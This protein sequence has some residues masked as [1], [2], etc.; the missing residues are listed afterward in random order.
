[1]RPSKFLI[2]VAAILGVAVGVPKAEA[3][4]KK[5]PV[6]AKTTAVKSAKKTTV[7]K[8]AR[9]KSEKKPVEKPMKRS[10]KK[11]P[12]ILA[13][14]TAEVLTPE[15]PHPHRLSPEFVEALALGEL[16]QAYHHLQLEEASDK[17][18]YMINQ[19]L[20]A[21]GKGSSHGASISPFDRATAWHNLYLFLARQGRPA[22]KFVKEAARYYLKAAHK[23]LYHEKSNVL[24][25]ALYATAGNAAKSEKFFSKVD[26]MALTHA[27]EDY[28]GLEY[29]AT[30]YAATQQVQKALRY[31]DLAY[32]LNPGSLLQWLHVGDDFWAIEED[33]SYQGQLALWQTRHKQRLA[34][35]QHD[36]STHDVRKK[37]ALNKKSKKKSKAR[38][39]R[40]E[41][42]R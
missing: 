26:I 7:P 22:P 35:L 28:N 19:V 27:E 8:I 4:V 25:A 34:Q 16:H 32:K 20:V 36:K 31:L 41:H 13:P 24:L 18:G 42:K 9:K 29:L 14:K 17:V 6:K 38:H 40:S 2:L 11:P 15:S 37:A 10:G 30:Y 3:L 5:T 39:P 1:M 21:Q 33:P 23:V 12:F